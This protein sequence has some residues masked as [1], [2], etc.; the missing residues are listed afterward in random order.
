MLEAHKRKKNR[1]L[2]HT[3]V[4][5]MALLVKQCASYGTEIVFGARMLVPN[6]S[7]PIFDAEQHTHCALARPSVKRSSG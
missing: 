7:F 1:F 5:L 6:Q 3:I 2:F 4:F